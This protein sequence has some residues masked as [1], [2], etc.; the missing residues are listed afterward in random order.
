[1]CGIILIFA[2]SMSLMITKAEKMI[3]GLEE[4]PEADLDATER[5]NTNI[6]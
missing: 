6:H 2:F 3:N 5:F 4:E 1:M